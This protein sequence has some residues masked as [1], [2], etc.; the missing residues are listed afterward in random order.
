MKI[1]EIKTNGKVSAIRVS[2][3]KAKETRVSETKAREIRIS[4]MI[5]KEKKD[6][7]AV[8]R[9]RIKEI[10]RIVDK[11]FCIIKKNPG[12]TGVFIFSEKYILKTT[13]GTIYFREIANWR[14]SIIDYLWNVYPI[15]RT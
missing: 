3:T 13:S 15:S 11:N 14:S 1:R 7:E 6:R 8:S 2:V 12:A 5:L 10:S 4:E 9:T